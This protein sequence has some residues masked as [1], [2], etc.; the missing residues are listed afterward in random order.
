MGK[1]GQWRKQEFV[2]ETQ[3][4]YPKKVCL[5]IWGDKIDQ[6]GITEGDEVNVAV[7]LES[8]EY[9]GKWYTEAR[10]WKVEKSGGSSSPSAP[11]PPMEEP[12]DN[13]GSDD[14]PF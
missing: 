11:P 12:T 10:A 4:Q 5:S 13:G 2:V 9:N 6:F 14:L 3:S 7:D 8:R 1:K